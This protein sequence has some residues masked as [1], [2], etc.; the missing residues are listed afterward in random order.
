MQLNKFLMT[1][2]NINFINKIKISTTELSLKVTTWLKGVVERFSI[3]DAITLISLF[4]CYFGVSYAA[5]YFSPETG[6]PRGR[7]KGIGMV[8]YLIHSIVCYIYFKLNRS[9]KAYSYSGSAILGGM[10]ALLILL[11]FTGAYVAAIYP[12]IF[13]FICKAILD[14]I[15]LLLIFYGKVKPHSEKIFPVYK[16]IFEI[17]NFCFGATLGF[18]KKW[19][20][21]LIIG[22]GIS[23]DSSQLVLMFF[24]I[25]VANVF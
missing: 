9:D 18:L 19:I 13:S 15:L 5:T 21:N 11:S 7:G 10:L 8:A 1:N 23:I 16:I 14:L 22:H 2:G 3:D 24:I 12:T 25:V 4:V 6:N 20:P 17:S